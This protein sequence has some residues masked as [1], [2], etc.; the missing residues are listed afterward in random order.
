MTAYT[1]QTPIYRGAERDGLGKDET[2]SA[3]QKALRPKGMKTMVMH[4]E[5]A[6][7]RYSSASHQPENMIHSHTRTW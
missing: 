1:K 3:N 4:M 7:N 6:A 5:I 2:H